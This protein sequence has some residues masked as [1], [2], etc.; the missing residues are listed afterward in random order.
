MSH[1]III[2]NIS[3]RI[4]NEVIKKQDNKCARKPYNVVNGLENYQCILWKAN[5]NKG[6]FI[7][8]NY[9][10]YKIDP[11]G[12]KSVS[13][14][15]ALCEQCFKV[16]QNRANRNNTAKSDDS[17]DS[18]LVTE[19]GDSTDSTDS[20][21]S[22]III[23]DSSSSSEEA[24]SAV[25]SKYIIIYYPNRPGVVNIRKSPSSNAKIIGDAYY[26]DIFDVYNIINNKWIQIIYQKN[27]GY[28]KIIWDKHIVVSEYDPKPIINNVENK[29]P[30]IENKSPSNPE[31]KICYEELV[32]R[33]VLIPCGHACI[34]KPCIDKLIICPICSVKIKKCQRI[35]D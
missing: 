35:Y 29:L 9:V 23:F 21:D 30:P 22:N 3:T 1:N 27:I 24:T 4:E 33:H 11:I 8:K 5:H 10:I 13:N 25:L 26:G 15:I 32:I 14:L 6:T 34:C 7:N 31:C 2:P 18:N 16:L 17:S 20:T 12:D 28:I 19:S